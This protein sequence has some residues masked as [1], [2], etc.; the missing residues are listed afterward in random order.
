MSYTVSSNNQVN[1]TPLIYD[2]RFHTFESWASLMCEAF[3]ANQLEIPGPTTPGQVWA[4]GIK[5]IGFFDTNGTPDPYAYENWD[6]W[7]T[8]LRN[9]YSPSPQ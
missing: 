4:S 9:S 1:V 7:A 3:A 6:D 8:E 5:A 2:P